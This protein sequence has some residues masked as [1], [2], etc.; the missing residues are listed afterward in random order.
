MMF[1]NHRVAGTM[2]PDNVARKM[3]IPEMFSGCFCIKI[4]SMFRFLFAYPMNITYITLY[5]V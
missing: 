1:Q 4:L 5:I 3:A 2:F